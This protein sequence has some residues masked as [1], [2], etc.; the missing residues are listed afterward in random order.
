MMWVEVNP[1]GSNTN[2]LVVTKVNSLTGGGHPDRPLRNSGSE[3][4]TVTNYGK[5]P[6]HNWVTKLT[7]SRFV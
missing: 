3:S 4:I 2:M 6:G 7:I 5:I 1:G